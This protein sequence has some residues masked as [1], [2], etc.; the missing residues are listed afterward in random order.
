MNLKEQTLW[1]MGK[2]KGI[3]ETV[4][5]IAGAHLSFVVYGLLQ[6]TM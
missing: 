3:L 1:R 4:A 6:E 2:A 5:Y